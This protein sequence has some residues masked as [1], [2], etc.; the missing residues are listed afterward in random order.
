MPRPL[1][2]GC[3]GNL[4]QA[5]AVLHASLQTARGSE[6]IPSGAE[7]ASQGYIPS[8]GGVVA[9]ESGGMEVTPRTT[10]DGAGPTNGP[11]RGQASG[12]QNSE[13]DTHYVGGRC[14]PLPLP[15]PLPLP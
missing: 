3:S 14:K 1:P 13:W 7:L 4:D 11:G 10:G 2:Q 5:V 15:L 8:T 6:Y 12:T 9:E